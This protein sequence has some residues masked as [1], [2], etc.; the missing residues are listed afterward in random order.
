[1]SPPLEAFLRPDAWLGA[2]LK[3]WPGCRYHLLHNTDAHGIEVVCRGHSHRTHHPGAA[4]V[5][6]AVAAARPA[7]GEATAATIVAEKETAETE[8]AS[9]KGNSAVI[10]GIVYKLASPIL[11]SNL[12][13]RAWRSLS[14][15]N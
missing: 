4:T 1:M 10:P 13:N 5:A 7:A 3:R 6:P 8:K 15:R 9:L 12:A 2:R 14:R 11:G